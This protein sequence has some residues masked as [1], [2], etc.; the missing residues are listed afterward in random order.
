MPFVNGLLKKKG[1]QQLVQY[2]YLRL[3][4]REDRRDARQPEEPRLHLRD[5]VGHLDRHRRPGHPGEEGR[6]SSSGA[7]DEVI[8]VEQ[9]YLEGAI[10][11]GE[12]YNKVIAIWSEVTEKIADEMFGEMDEL[13]KIGRELQPGLHHGRLRRPRHRSSR[14]ASWPAC[15]A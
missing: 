4:A 6:S 1:L 11:N 8:K 13:D 10:T 3:R 7:R 12:R 9:Q 15:A 14:S 2:C 5:A